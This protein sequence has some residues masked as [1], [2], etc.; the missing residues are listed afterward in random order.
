MRTPVIICFLLLCLSLKASDSLQPRLDTLFV[1]EAVNKETAL[2]HNFQTNIF[3]K[4]VC[5]LPLSKA[6]EIT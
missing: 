3:Y 2:L 6:P 4:H 5:P 1:E